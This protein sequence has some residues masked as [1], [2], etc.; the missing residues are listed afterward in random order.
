MTIIEE[1]ASVAAEKAADVPA[2]VLDVARRSFVD[3]IGTIFAGRREPATRI[4]SRVANP[5][6]GTAWVVTGGA[7]DPERAVLINATAAHAIDFDD[8][9][10]TDLSGHPSAILVPVA[11]A[12]GQGSD[13]T[14]AD[15]YRA[16]VAGFEVELRIARW[17]NPNLFDIGFHPTSTLGVFG[18]CAAAAHLR[19]ANI[20]QTS[21]ALAIA[22]SLAA[23][24]KA[25]FGTMTKPLHCGWA[26]RS[27]VL[28][29]DLS[30]AGLTANTSALEDRLGFAEAFARTSLEAGV[31]ENDRDRWAILEPGVD[32]RKAWPV[33]GS[34][35]T[36][37]EAGLQVRDALS[38]DLS[39]VESVEI[40][41][42]AR[43]VPQIDRPWPAS[44]QDA[45]Y[46]AQYVTVRAMLD[47]APTQLDFVED[48][49]VDPRVEQLLGRTRLVADVRQTART[50][51]LDGRD[52]GARV[53]VQ[54]RGGQR[55]EATVDDPVGGRTRPMSD[56]DLTQKFLENVGREIGPELAD[57]LL[58]ALMDVRQPGPMLGALPG[59]QRSDSNHRGD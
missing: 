59:L 44:G 28:A 10:T 41:V 6:G 22:T 53:T 29:V 38:G 30:L 23:G 49:L 57:R 25:N 37:I 40:G 31:V 42:H 51:T 50:H 13:R 14:L 33:C 18:A 8:A 3:T 4:V 12:V 55:V 9:T 26:A 16:Y 54:L 32:L 2:P 20:T 19:R 24:I 43:R 27:G 46:S 47:G 58:V 17:L 21:R 39:A 45:R 7:A 52:L 11:L 15:A 56:S 36:A 5:T 48:A 1:L 35:I 34:V